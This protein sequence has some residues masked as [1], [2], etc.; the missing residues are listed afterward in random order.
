MATFN[1]IITVIFSATGWCAFGLSGSLSPGENFDLTHWKLQLPDDD[2]SSILPA[3]LE[4][5]YES[6]WFWT[7]GSDGSMAFYVK[8]DGGT[9]PN[10]EYPRSELRQRCNPTASSSDSYNWKIWDGN[11][12][13][14]SVKYEIGWIDT[15]SRKIVLQQ[16]KAYPSGPPLLKMKWQS[17]KVYALVK[18][19]YLGENEESYFMGDAPQWQIF[20]L[21]SKVRDGVLTLYWNQEILH[22]I[23]I[24][25]YWTWPGNYFKA[26]NYLQSND[27]NAY[28]VV[29]IHYLALTNDGE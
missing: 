26:G 25:H 10:S 3:Q 16:I 1:L 21:K 5:G 29:Y 28:A 9:S 2:F 17:G 18:T 7:A 12:N 13:E 20:H 14:V 4:A 27:P 15:F 6:E 8:G 23:P 19:D 11:K 22:E 24:D